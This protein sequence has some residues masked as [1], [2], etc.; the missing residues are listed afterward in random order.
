MN[1]AALIADD[2]P[3]LAAD[4]KRRIASLWPELE[5]RAVCHDGVDA[6]ARLERTSRTSFPTSACR[7]SAD[8]TWQRP[9]IFPAALFS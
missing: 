3:L 5:I 6:L 7:A 1:P 8:W 2:E 4:L 9:S